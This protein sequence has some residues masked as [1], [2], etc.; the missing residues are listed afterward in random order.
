MTGEIAKAAMVFG[1]MQ[2]LRGSGAMKII[3]MCIAVNARFHQREQKN[4]QRK[5]SE[6]FFQFLHG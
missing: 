4:K 6:Y 5:N 2:M 1:F 3:S